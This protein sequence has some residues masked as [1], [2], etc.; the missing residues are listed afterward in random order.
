MHPFLISQPAAEQ[1]PGMVPD[2]RLRRGR[3]VCHRP[4][5][6]GPY[7]PSAASHRAARGLTPRELEVLK[8]V[9]Q[10]LTNRAIARHLVLSEHAVCRHVTTILRKLNVSSRAAT[11]AWGVG[12]G[13]LSANEAS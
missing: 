8:L 6:A 5:R 12:C 1:R 2:T 10:G 4:S 9:A 3:P 11:A 7:V 13:Y